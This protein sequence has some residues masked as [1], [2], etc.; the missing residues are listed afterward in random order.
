MKFKTH[1]RSFDVETKG[2][3]GVSEIENISIKRINDEID[4]KMKRLVSWAEE[5]EKRRDIFTQFAYL[6]YLGNSPEKHI[7]NNPTCFTEK[8]IKDVLRYVHPKKMEIIRDLRN[9]YIKTFNPDLSFDCN[10]LTKLGFTSCGMCR[11]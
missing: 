9:L 1:I 6:S 3:S 11:K 10:L 2:N 7:M 5:N 4:Y 8:E